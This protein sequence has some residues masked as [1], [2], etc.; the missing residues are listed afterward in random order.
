MAEAT[1]RTEV[2]TPASRRGSNLQLTL[3]M[4]AIVLTGAVLRLYGL[5]RTSIWLDEALSWDAARRPFWSMVRAT[6]NET[7]QPL[8]NIILYG[9]IRLFG[10]SAIALRLPSVIL[11]VANIYLLYRLGAVLWDRTTGAFGAAL[12]AIS[13]FHLWYSQEARMYSLFALAATAFVLASIEFLRQPNRLSAALCTA[14]GLALLYSH[15]FATWVWVGINTALA[16]A[17]LRHGDWIAARGRSWLAT[18]GLAGLVFLPWAIVLQRQARHVMHGFWIPFPTPD[19]LYAMAVSIAGGAAMLGCLLL[20]LLLS[21]LPA[22]AS[23]AVAQGGS[24]LRAFRRPVAL[25]P[26]EPDIGWQ[27]VIL[28]SW[29]L[30]PFLIGYVVSTVGRP[31]L[32]NRYLIGSLPA[33]M[34]LAARGLR[35]LCFNRLVLLGA[36]VA[37][38]VFSIPMLHFNL[39]RRLREDDRAAVATFALNF[40]SSDLVVFLQPYMSIPFSYYFRAPIRPPVVIRNAEI[41]DVDGLG[42]DRIWL[43]VREANAGQSAKLFERIER[44]Y[45]RKQE[46]Q[47]FRVA[48]YL[49]IRRLGGLHPAGNSVDAHAR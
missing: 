15:P 18:Q 45:V 21:F 10:D 3:V 5:D 40:R 17:L 4:L 24:A 35:V 23:A 26:F 31:I 41:D 27:K 2:P 19:L 29:L 46:F 39:T 36:V 32:I 49:Y 43:F 7:S 47:F 13:G 20:L 37:L 1:V 9:A 6:A 33:L 22:P 28:L 12:L 8:H 34:L 16:A 48:V 38:L 30:V 14:T 44:S 11:G 42:A 25:A